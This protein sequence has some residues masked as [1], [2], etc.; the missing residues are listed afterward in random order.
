MIILF[1]FFLPLFLY[2]ILHRFLTPTRSFWLRVLVLFMAFVSGVT[3]IAITG[4]SGHWPQAT[5]IVWTGVESSDGNLNIGG[6]REEAIIGWSNGSFAPELKA[7]FDG[8]KK[9]SLQLS[10]GG[11][12]VF[13][14]TKKV[15]L[16]SKLLKSGEALTSDSLNVKLSSSL[17]GSDVI[18][19]LDSSNNSLTKVDVPSTNKTKDH[20]FSMASLVAQKQSNNEQEAK[21]ISQAAKW[22][23]N[24]RLMRVRNGEVRF[25]DEESKTNECELPC[26]LTFN[27][28][29]Q[30]L[31][32]VINGND[33]KLAL[34]FLPP[35]RVASPLPPEDNGKRILTIT[36]NPRPDDKAF[37][38]PI[39][40]ALQD[41]RA[42]IEF[43][44]DKDGMPVFS[45]QGVTVGQTAPNY[46]PRDMQPQTEEEKLGTG[47]NVT[48]RLVLP[49]GTTTALTLATVND[50]PSVKGIALFL[51][52]AF[53]A[54]AAGVLITANSMP[55]HNVR[56]LALGIAAVLWN[57]LA[58]RLLLSLRF[59]LDPHFLDSLTVKGVTLS[60]VAITI[61]PAIIFLWLR[62]RFHSI[63][64][65]DDDEKKKAFIVSLICCA[66]I[67]I[68]LCVMWFG[69]PHLWANM[70]PR[71][72]PPLRW[73]AMLLLILLYE[74][75]VIF[76]VYRT[77]LEDK[78][79]KVFHG[80]FLKPLQLDLVLAERG[81]SLWADIAV[82]EKGGWL[83]LL[84]YFVAAI[85]I[86]VLLPL[87]ILFLLSF[88]LL[89]SLVREVVILFCFC[90]VPALLWLASKIYLTPKQKETVS[91][92]RLFWISCLIVPPIFVLPF[93]I[94]DSGSVLATLSLFVPMIFL[95]LARR[96]WRQGWMALAVLSVVM[97]FAAFFVYKNLFGYLPIK[98]GESEIRLLVFQEGADTLARVLFTDT[99][100]KLRKLQNTYLHTWEDQAMIYE[101]QW[102]GLG[103]G[104]APTRLSQVS[105]NT[106][107]YDSLF[108]FF[109][110][111]EHGFIGSTAFLLMYSIPLLL[112]LKSG[113]QAHFDYGRACGFVIASA[114][115]LEAIF[116][117]GMNAGAFPL[118]G[119]NS[120]LLSVNSLTDLLR[121]LFLFAFI[122][123]ALLW[124][125]SPQAKE[126]NEAEFLPVAEE[127]KEAK[128]SNTEESKAKARFKNQYLAA[129]GVLLIVP[130][131]MLAR[132]VLANLNVVLDKSYQNPFEWK[133][134]LARVDQM[135]KDGLIEV[136]A[137]TGNLKSKFPTSVPNSTLIE[138]EI[139]R[140]N[141]LPLN[142]K[143]DGASNTDTN[144]KLK[145]V[146]SV[147]E[148]NALLDAMRKED[149]AQIK[150]TRPTLFRLLP[151][152]KWD[153]GGKIEQR[154]GYRV[155]TNTAFNSQISFLAGTKPENLP[156]VT[157]RNGRKV[158]GPAW[159][160]G[161]WVTTFDPLV[162]LSWLKHLGRAMDAEWNPRAL[163]PTEAKKRYGTLSL[164]ENLHKAAIELTAQKGITS[165]QK[166]FEK[167]EDEKNTVAENGFAENEL[168]VPPRIALTVL[169][170]PTGEVLALGGYP[171]MTAGNEWR[172]YDK[173]AG[174]LPSSEWVEQQA[175]FSLRLLYGG[176][177]N[178]DRMIVGSATKPL[179]ASA[180]LAV[181]E[182][183]NQRFAV[184]GGKG[185]ENGIF[186]ININGD[187]WE[188]PESRW[189]N[190][191]DYLAWSDNRYHIRFG[192]L[193]LVEGNDKGIVTDGESSSVNES[194]NGGKNVWGKFP[195][196]QSIAFSNKQPNKIT[197]LEKTKLAGHFERM[198][199][200]VVGE[201]KYSDR[202]S[203]WTKNEAD[204]LV[205][206]NDS[207]KANITRLFAAISP[208][209]TNLALNDIEEPRDFISV[210]L[211]GGSNRWSNVDLA[212]SFG[213]CLTG[214]PVVAHIVKNDK[215]FDFF[216]EKDNPNS[217]E[218]FTTV[219]AKL[220]DG[221][222]KVV[223]SGTATEKLKESGAT[224]YISFLKGKGYKIYAKTGTLRE[225]GTRDISRIVF[226]I[227]KWEDEAQGKI[228]SGMIFSLVSERAETGTAT[229]W[230]GEFLASNAN[231]KE[232]N[233]LVGFK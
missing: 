201:K 153:N 29:S 95:L 71:F 99:N 169:N 110:A 74:L 49:L 4:F 31:P 199:A 118:T 231:Q 87:T 219:A 21:N 149:V 209:R 122:A 195:K 155:T 150:D 39:G 194:M 115:L 147:A 9:I 85:L 229:K 177:R 161:K 233:R 114:F 183:L 116:H 170:L 185:F 224:D 23:S 216:D 126:M 102:R 146:K 172:S 217:R 13:D 223:I 162:S 173:D 15:F 151:P 187:A 96:P 50:L 67:L 182:N 91:L 25:L 181:H 144:Q 89:P 171:R 63:K 76:V 58:F 133:G 17:F 33:K 200:V 142:E 212:A 158:I 198:F 138:Q 72:L 12:F 211:G 128:T 137:T 129:V 206:N 103:Y 228:K 22:A 121:W 186:G 88:V 178:F 220:R 188:V 106:L 159:V 18:E 166:M 52:I 27:W 124:R 132:V 14:E 204:D 105:Q 75:G 46:F 101:G 40:Y 123:Q 11:A 214:K 167:K 145:E 53:A 230:L 113:R 80:I 213:T 131:F 104:N 135:I 2:L 221:L 57:F 141:A 26:R 56:R 232:I 130:V 203:F 45:G 59:A 30:R 20:V 48:S 119:R 83:R 154:G 78:R 19:I 60:F 227:V 163:G 24:K 94:G 205:N 82:A 139:L 41:P 97:L 92:K 168:R 42:N 44:K 184:N 190:F 32:V 152:L 10:N 109:I 35:W 65:L 196:F 208:E 69:V 3:I 8:A 210:L 98:I 134:V 174:W 156:S 38:L 160:S 73:F 79:L 86:F 112:L 108:S 81:K 226:A 6:V 207:S 55:D 36:A 37:V 107:Q 47:A 68:L 192:F 43:A 62:L 90:L 66:V 191:T 7:K 127:E 100:D 16:N 197:D 28:S 120:P 222:E 64:K 5:Q 202:Y 175:P 136:D 225:T 189:R 180:T 215:P 176:D 70:Q 77:D 164:D 117:A 51:L 54:Y 93:V 193:G 179:W 111:S 34:I 125:Y 148:F 165:Y 84:A 1:C 143:L 157:F 61:V 218:T 140:F